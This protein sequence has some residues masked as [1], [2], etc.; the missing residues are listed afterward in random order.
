MWICYP[1]CRTTR[2]RLWVDNADHCRASLFGKRSQRSLFS[3]LQIWGGLINAG[4]PKEGRLCSTKRLVVVDGDGSLWHNMWL[5]SFQSRPTMRRIWSNMFLKPENNIVWKLW[6]LSIIY[7]C[8][9]IMIYLMWKQ[10]DNPEEN[11]S[12]ALHKSATTQR[13]KNYVF[14]FY[15]GITRAFV[16]SH[17]VSDGNPKT[18]STAQRNVECT[19]QSKPQGIAFIIAQTQAQSRDSLCGSPEMHCKISV[20]SLAMPT[21][22]INTDDY[23]FQ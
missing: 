3:I 17:L 8:W 14:F 7:L 4:S 10:Q 5:P 16:H 23:C 9:I 6:Q 12:R 11:P 18:N 20:L 1:L 21:R 19:S 2:K 22:A 13:N 15:H